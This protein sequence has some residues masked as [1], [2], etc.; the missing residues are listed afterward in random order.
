MSNARDK[1]VLLVEKRRNTNNLLQILRMFLCKI[2][3]LAVIELNTRAA[4]N[5]LILGVHK[6]LQ[7]SCRTMTITQMLVEYEPIICH[8]YIVQY[9]QW[10][11]D[12]NWLDSV[13]W[14]LGI[15]QNVGWRCL[16]AEACSTPKGGHP[17]HRIAA[18]AIA[19]VPIAIVFFEKLYFSVYTNGF[20]KYV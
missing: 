11:I 10:T 3:F 18:V 1:S 15:C 7:K 8:V 9:I 14:N 4:A 20:K 19:A 16:F 5:L 12:L 13:V 17:F 2:S 6:W